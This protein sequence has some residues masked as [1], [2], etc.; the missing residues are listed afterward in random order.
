VCPG[1][2]GPVKRGH[3]ALKGLGSAR[4]EV[5]VATVGK[6]LV[7]P[8]LAVALLPWFL[9]LESM[10]GKAAVLCAA[11]PTAANAFVVAKEHETFVE[12]ASGTIL[13]STIA[14]V[15]TVSA[16]LVLLRVG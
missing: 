10:C 7:Q 16:L 11:L 5:G 1:T 14:S 9:D 15:A 3:E 4:T 12:G 13:L 2:A 8:L 6:V